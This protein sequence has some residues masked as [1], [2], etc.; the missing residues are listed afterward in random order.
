MSRDHKQYLSVS[1][2]IAL[3]M[4]C[5][6]TTAQSV[7]GEN[8]QEPA[9][10][11]VIELVW[12]QD[13][14]DGFSLQ[15]SQFLN[16][17]WGEPEVLYRSDNPITTPALGTSPAGDKLLIWTEQ[18]RRKTVLKSMRRAVG[19]SWQEAQVF[20][21]S[22]LEN[23]AV[24]IVYDGNGEGWV[25]WSS[26]G[27][28]L[29]DIYLSRSAGTGWSRRQRIHA[30]NEVPDIMPAASITQQGNVMVEWT[31]YSFDQGRYI[32]TSKEFQVE[33]ID[34]AN[35]NNDID[36]E[37]AVLRDLSLPEFV[38]KNRRLL[39]HFPKHTMIQSRH[40]SLN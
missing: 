4:L 15:L 14:E 26:A 11:M 8:Q 13:D 40:L 34:N 32:L 7:H 37:S 12:A 20:S 25:F 36:K 6:P 21:D 35:K 17:L 19:G 27:G 31:Q 18:L 28:E 9:Q 5:G 33:K 38:P 2:F 30:E 1:F 16:Q 24:S 29:A 23:F 3:L 10:G 39:L 22:G